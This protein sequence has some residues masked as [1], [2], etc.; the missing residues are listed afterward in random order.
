MG[1]VSHEVGNQARAELRVRKKKDFKG[2]LSRY[3]SLL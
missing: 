2:E 3:I 1:A